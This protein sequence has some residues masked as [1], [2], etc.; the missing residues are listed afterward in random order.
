MIETLEAI[1]VIEGI[2]HVLQQ[3]EMPSGIRIENSKHITVRDNV[4]INCGID[5]K[6]SEEIDVFANMIDD[7]TRREIIRLLY[8]LMALV[9]YNPQDKT[10]IRGTLDKLKQIAEPIY[11]LL[12]S[13]NELKSIVGL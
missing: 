6:N 11:Y 13:I 4:L 2:I 5:V 9:K 10:E 3:A 12:V 8:E 1:E 7:E